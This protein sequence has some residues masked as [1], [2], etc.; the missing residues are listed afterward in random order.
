MLICDPCLDAVAVQD[1]SFAYDDG[2]TT[3]KTKWTVTVSEE[4]AAFDA[5]QRWADGVAGGS[6]GKSCTS[7]RKKS[8]TCSGMHTA[9]RPLC[10]EA[11]EAFLAASK[12][13]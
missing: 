4:I 7:R 5:L 9:K 3:G 12:G 11:A 6:C 8:S 1:F 2:R 10:R 13:S